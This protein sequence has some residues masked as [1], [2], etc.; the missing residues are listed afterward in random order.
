LVLAHLRRRWSLRGRE[1]FGVLEKMKCLFSFTPKVGRSG[2][3]ARVFLAKK[4]S[5]DAGQG[6]DRRWH[7]V[8]RLTLED[9]LWRRGVR[10]AGVRATDANVSVCRSHAAE[11]AKHW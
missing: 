9:G 6:S 10:R 2:E 1:G 4:H 3:V 11:A 8:C 5:T 7:R